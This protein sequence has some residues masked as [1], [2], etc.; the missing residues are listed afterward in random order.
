M[1]V[2]L[3]ALLLLAF[4]VV[5]SS[6]RREY[7]FSMIAMIALAL[8]LII[9]HVRE[10]VQFIVYI[11]AFTLAL[12]L[13]RAPKPWLVRSAGILVAVAAMLVAYRVWNACTERTCR[14]TADRPDA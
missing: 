5:R 4:E 9:V 6:S 13:A 8:M 2:L 14:A 1:G 10:I 11:A 7:W 3:P 12:A